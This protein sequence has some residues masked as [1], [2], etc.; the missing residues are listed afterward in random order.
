M[1]TGLIHLYT[2]PGKGKTTA[3]LGLAL[4]SLGQGN[5][6]LIVQFM[7]G[8]SDFG[9]L[10]ALRLLPS[11]QVVQFGRPDFVDRDKPDPKD[12]DAAQQGVV[13]AET[14]FREGYDLIVLD[15]IVCAVDFSLLDVDQVIHLLRAKPDTLELVLTGRNAPQALIDLA[16]YVTVMQEIKHP[17]TRGISARKGVEY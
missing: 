2:G 1:E 15:E 5:R 11:V 4:R 16:D 17:F 9:E 12:V 3:A 8:R 7:K 10:E 14:A 13:F 6:V